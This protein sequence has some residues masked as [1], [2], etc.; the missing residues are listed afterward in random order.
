MKL[1][2][3]SPLVSVPT[4]AVAGLAHYFLVALCFWQV[5]SQHLPYAMWLAR[6]GLRGGAW[7]A[8]VT[9]MDLVLNILIALPAAW[10]V[11]RVAGARVWLHLAVAILPYALWSIPWHLAEPAYESHRGLTLGMWALPMC[12]LPAAAGVWLWATRWPRRTG[13]GPLPG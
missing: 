13:L 5:A 2:W 8:T 12:F 9:G 4:A 11:L 3:T 10:A 7:W 1:R 6:A